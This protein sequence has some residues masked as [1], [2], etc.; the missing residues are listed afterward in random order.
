[1]ANR[2][3][4][5]TA[6]VETTVLY[7]NSIHLCTVPHHT[8]RK[9]N[10]PLA[11]FYDSE[12][13]IPF[14]LSETAFSKHLLLLGGIGSGK[15]N[16]IYWIIDALLRKL[17]SRDL[18]LVFDSKG[19]FFQKFY[20]PWDPNHIV[21]GNHDRYAHNTR[22]WNIF[23]ELRNP[24]GGF[25][26]SSALAAKEIAKSLFA[27]RESQNQPFFSLAAT[28]VVAKVLQDFYTH[29]PPEELNNAELVSFFRTANAEAYH[30]MIDRNPEF[31]SAR[32]YFGTRGAT[33]TPQTL[34]VMSYIT[35]MVNDIFIGI[36]GD[37]RPGRSFSMRELVRRKGR[38]IVFIEYDL[39]VGEILGPIY[40]LLYDLALKEALGGRE[41]SGNTYLICDE[42]RIMPALKHLNDALNLGRSLGLK[43]IAGLQTINQLYDVYEEELG[44]TLAAGFMNS[45]CLQTWDLDTRKFIADRFGDNYANL[46]F[47]S[48]NNPLSTQ[49]EGHVV[50]DWD[51]LNLRV[52]EAFVNLNGEKPFRFRF[53]LFP[54]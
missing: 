8:A 15:T 5:G 10:N 37:H 38:K 23:D 27:G 43:V 16:C 44:K 2:Y 14:G 47:H 36:F 52:G 34:G 26:S 11:V 39:N 41:H 53:Q 17:T 54:E 12:T 4:N 45:I 46:T 18:M 22:C 6:D 50:E 28:D 49:R 25:D 19:D 40:G 32:D 13:N 31:E 42:L 3:I 51:I 29:R 35:T 48:M 9:E 33:L 7:G 24:A 1:M 21:I 20:N 30:R